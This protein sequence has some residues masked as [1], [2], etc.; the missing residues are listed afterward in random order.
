[1]AYHILEILEQSCFRGNNT[2]ESLKSGCPQN[3]SL[4]ESWSLQVPS[5]EFWPCSH[6]TSSNG[7]TWPRPNS[8]SQ[9]NQRC[10]I[11]VNYKQSEWFALATQPIRC[12]HEIRSRTLLLSTTSDA[13]P[14]PHVELSAQLM[15]PLGTSYSAPLP[16][17][18]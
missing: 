9:P 15:F 13:P 2:E 5:K 11:N 8:T 6:Q 10:L 1:M 17:T 14:N 12:Y 4:G 16:F 7:T 3:Y 18:L